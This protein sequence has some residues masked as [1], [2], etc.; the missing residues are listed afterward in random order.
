MKTL[1]AAL[2]ASL[3]FLAPVFADSMI[4]PNTGTAIG[5]YN[6]LPTIKMNV[7]YAQLEVGGSLSNVNSQNNDQSKET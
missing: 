4:I 1:I 2:I 7:P 5:V 3:L 6:N